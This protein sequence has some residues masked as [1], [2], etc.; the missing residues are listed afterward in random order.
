MECIIKVSSWGDDLVA[1]FFMG[2]G[3]TQKAALKH[4]RWSWVWK[5]KRNGLNRLRGRYHYRD[6]SDTSRSGILFLFC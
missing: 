1:D 3:A 2:F 5:W 4:N 6:K